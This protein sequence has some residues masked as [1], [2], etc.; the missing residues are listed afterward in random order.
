[1]HPVL[2][3]IGAIL[4]P[5]Y[6][7]LAAVGVLLA[8]LLAQRTARI[9][10]LNPGHVWN[11]CV[12]SLFTALV[13]QRLLL[14]V[15]NLRDLRRH[16]SW[17]LALAMVHHPLLAAAGALAG[18]GAAVICAHWLKL[19]FRTTA[20]VL[21]A[22]LA[23]GLAFEQLGAL[24][25][26]SG[27]GTETGV[28]WAVTYNYAMAAVWSGTPLGIPLHPVQAYAALAFL[29]LSIFLLVW[30]PAIRQSGDLAGMGLMGT[31]VAVYITE[32]WRDTEGRGELLN[33]ALDGPQVGAIVLVLAG[34]LVLLKRNDRR[35]ESEAVHG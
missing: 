6:G 32:L 20:D 27:Y 15:I 30:Q 11:L 22:P 17:L 26:G 3:H 8:L 18:I 2:F 12:V 28:R 35:T 5:S 10:G 19:P 29:S 4:I 7:A 16:P 25:A 13:A 23:L 1:M 34:A 33:G 9:A 31:G 14:V 24:L 21:S